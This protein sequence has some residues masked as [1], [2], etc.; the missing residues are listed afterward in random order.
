MRLHF[1]GLVSALS[2]VAMSSAFAEPAVQAG[3]T[4]ESLSQ[5]KVA[6]TVNGQPASLV[7]LVQSGQ[8]K[9]VDPNQAAAPQPAPETA[10]NAAPAS[11]AEAPQPAPQPQQPQQ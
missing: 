2:L 10:P 11:Q 1:I 5:V 7:E 4:L 8:I 9:L 3:E 6:T